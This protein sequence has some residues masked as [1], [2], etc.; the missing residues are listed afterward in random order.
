MDELIKRI[1]VAW[2]HHQGYTDAALEAAPNQHRS[3]DCELNGYEWQCH[4]EYGNSFH[5]VWDAVIEASEMANVIVESLGL[6]QEW[7]PIV[8]D[9][10]G[11]TWPRWNEWYDDAAQAAKAVTDDPGTVLGTAW[12]TDWERSDGS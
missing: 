1:A 6:T 4:D 10:D 8:V 2:L 12:V 7:A 5:P 11:R 9:D 3:Y